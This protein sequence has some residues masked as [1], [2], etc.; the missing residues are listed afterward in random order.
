MSP[1]C[2]YSRSAALRSVSSVS[3][4]GKTCFP[5]IA[6]KLMVAYPAAAH[7]SP[8]RR[9]FLGE[10][11]E[12]K[13]C[14]P[15]IELSTRPRRCNVLFRRHKQPDLDRR[16]RHKFLVY[17]SCSRHASIKRWAA[18]TKQMLDSHLFPQHAHGRWQVDRLVLA[19]NDQALLRQSALADVPLPPSW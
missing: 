18:F 9:R 16:N 15:H 10:S 12:H 4:S 3:I 2:M 17:Q 19:G 13:R 8:P 14:R 6:I 11:G 7:P 1:S 5:S